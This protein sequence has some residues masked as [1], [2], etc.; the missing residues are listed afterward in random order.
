MYSH[1]V[2]HGVE[3]L[4]SR[5]VPQVQR[6][7]AVTEVDLSDAE[8]TAER[9]CTVRVVSVVYVAFVQVG[10]TDPS[11]PDQHHY[12]TREHWRI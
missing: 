5:R 11:F 9:R 8:V 3:A 10:F 4:L 12:K 2:G 7:L 6:H 1:A